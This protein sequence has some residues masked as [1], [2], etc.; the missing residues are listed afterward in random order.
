MEALT[1]PR[2]TVQ[3][4]GRKAP[5]A[6]RVGGTAPAPLPRGLSVALLAGRTTA[7][8]VLLLISHDPMASVSRELW[9]Q[10]PDSRRVL[11]AV[12]APGD[13]ISGPWGPWG[14]L[15]RSHRLSTCLVADAPVSAPAP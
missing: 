2:G 6:L 8:P 7:H 3:S 9:L 10:Q 12:V 15:S 11:R 13:I 14:P 1:R 5:P 4:R